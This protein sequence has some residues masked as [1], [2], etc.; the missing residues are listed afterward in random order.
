[1]G[2]PLFTL[3]DALIASLAPDL[4]IT[5]ALCDVC[6]VNESDVRALA[7]RIV[8]A[9]RVVSVSGSTLDGI[10][11]DIATIGSAIDAEGDAAELL[12]GLRYRMRVVH[13]VLKA[14]RAPRPRVV[15]I[16]WTDPMYAGGHWVPEQVARAGGV[17]ML[18]TAGTHSV[19]V[20]AEQVRR[21]TPEIVIVAPCGFG[22]DRAVDEAASLVSTHPWL[23]ASQ[24]WAMDGNALTS[25]PGPHVV[26]GIEAMAHIF[27]PTLFPLGDPALARRIAG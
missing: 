4:I 10:F 27:A 3:D 11:L 2:Q 5:Q 24:V 6:A 26:D 7:A 17:D 15:V 25:R 12:L 21:A 14:A 20:S 22:I 16:E 9:P 19:C 8:P 1:M 18:A 23:A 13:N